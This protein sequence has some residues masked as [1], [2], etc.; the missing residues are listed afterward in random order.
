MLSHHGET[1]LVCD[2]VTAWPEL[3]AQ[4]DRLER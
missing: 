1:A 4:P 2:L 3:R